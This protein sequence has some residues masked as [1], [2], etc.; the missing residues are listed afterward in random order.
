MIIGVFPTIAPPAQNANHSFF[1]YPHIY[2]RSTTIVEHDPTS[3]YIKLLY[4]ISFGAP[5]IAFTS[6]FN[7]HQLNAHILCTCIKQHWYCYHGNKVCS[8]HH[9]QGIPL[10]CC[11]TGSNVYYWGSLSSGQDGNSSGWDKRAEL[12]V[13]KQI[14]AVCDILGCIF[15]FLREEGRKRSGGGAEGQWERES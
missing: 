4:V 12:W 8:T 5:P 7:L 14:S 9:L 13:W 11:T 6:S 1:Y 15:F 3:S 2:P 10:R